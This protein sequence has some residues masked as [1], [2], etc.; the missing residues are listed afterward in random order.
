MRTIL[1]LAAVAGLLASTTAP[2][3]IHFDRGMLQLSGDGL[4]ETLLLSPGLTASGFSFYDY[5]ACDGNEEGCIGLPYAGRR[6]DGSWS[7]SITDNSAVHRFDLSQGSDIGGPLEH[8]YFLE[9]FFVA[10][11]P[12]KAQFSGDSDFAELDC[13]GCIRV[14]SQGVGGMMQRPDGLW[15][16]NITAL[17]Q[18]RLAQGGQSLFQAGAFNLAE[19]PEPTSW[20]MLVAGFGLM[21][22][23]MRRRRHC[24]V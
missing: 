12:L 14:N 21:C 16:V 20:A 9:L 1:S 19:V 18:G 23:A 13:S 15:E 17:V 4:S 22:A 8:E 10:D 2:A 3:A 11:R 24:A 5:S 7:I 6:A